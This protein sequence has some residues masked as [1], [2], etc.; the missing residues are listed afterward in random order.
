MHVYKQGMQTYL[1]PCT[2]PWLWVY[3]QERV[4]EG[5]KYP[6]ISAASVYCDVF[7]GLWVKAWATP[8][9]RLPTSAAHPHTGGT[10]GGRPC[11]GNVQGYS[12]IASHGALWRTP[13]KQERITAESKKE[14]VELLHML[15]RSI[16]SSETWADVPSYKRAKNQ[17]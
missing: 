16:S 15:K 8:V 3:R 5:R 4:A 1:F 12:G 10:G 7:S 14:L 13:S 6:S 11:D 9:V 2:A 17:C